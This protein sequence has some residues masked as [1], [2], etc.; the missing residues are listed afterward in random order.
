ML[1]FII[2]IAVAITTLVSAKLESS[3]RH[4]F[5]LSSYTSDTAP[6]KKLVYSRTYIP[7]GSRIEEKQI[8]LKETSDLESFDDVQTELADVVGRTVKHAIPSQAQIRKI[9][10]E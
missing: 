3:Q 5:Q 6:Q 7:T 8:E 10:L 2:G 1:L 9:D 4:L